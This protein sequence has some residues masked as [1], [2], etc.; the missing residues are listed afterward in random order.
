M[1]AEVETKKSVNGEF[2]VLSIDGL[3]ICIVVNPRRCQY[4]ACNV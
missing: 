1:I 2:L 4:Q 3:N